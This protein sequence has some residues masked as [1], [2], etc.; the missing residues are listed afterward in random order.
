MTGPLALRVLGPVEAELDAREVELGGAKPRTVLAALLLA[1][2][3]TVRDRRLSE[4]LWGSTPPKTQSAQ[5]YTYASRLRHSLGSGVKITRLHHAYQLKTVSAVL[6]HDAFVEHTELGARLLAVG[7]HP[8]AYG[9]FG[10]AL[11]QWTGPVLGNTTPWLAEAE[12]PALVTARLATLENW[13]SVGL[14]LGHGDEVIAGLTDAVA[15][16]PGRERM[17]SLLM[18]A[19]FLCARQAEALDLYHEG[20]IALSTHWGIDPGNELKETYQAILRGRLPDV[21][22]GCSATDDALQS[23]RC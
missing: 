17:R 10:T 6:D 20:R 7:D 19:L 18:A 23:H 2:G 22:A 3:R 16:H 1:P 5:L 13:A 21:V 11:E 8:G 14:S 9:A 4:L 15:E 12:A